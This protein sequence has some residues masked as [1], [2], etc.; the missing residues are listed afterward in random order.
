MMWVKTKAV[1]VYSEHNTAP[2]TAVHLLHITCFHPATSLMTL[3]S[4]RVRRELH[5]HL[6]CLA[7]YKQLL[8][9]IRLHEAAILTQRG[10]A[11]F[12]DCHVDSPD[13]NT[14]G[15]S[16]CDDSVVDHHIVITLSDKEKYK[17]TY[18]IPLSRVTPSQLVVYSD[19]PPKSLSPIIRRFR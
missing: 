12:S 17:M 13:N 16:K 4:N 1:F 3:T 5:H 9:P 8:F 10:N 19:T 2:I 14:K 11:P 15:L 18:F 7:L 6:V